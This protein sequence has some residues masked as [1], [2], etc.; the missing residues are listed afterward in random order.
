MTQHA[1]EKILNR[2]G[3]ANFWHS[4]DSLFLGEEL[5]DYFLSHVEK[6]KHGF[7]E[8]TKPLKVFKKLRYANSSRLDYATAALTIPV[9]AT[10]YAPTAAFNSR[11]DQLFLRKMRASEAVVH[12]VY[13]TDE[14]RRGYPMHVESAHSLWDRNFEY[15]PG[16]I[17]K[18]RSRFSRKNT[19]CE[20]GIHFFINYLDAYNY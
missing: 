6:T 3:P 2:I 19:A 20:S 16:T 13:D 5:R 11:A 9:G 12:S 8:I 7:Y 4:Q 18:P 17:V 14:A 15:R 1:R 10:V